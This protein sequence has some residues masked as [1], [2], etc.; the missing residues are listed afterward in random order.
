ML[1]M[2]TSTNRKRRNEKNN[3]ALGMLGNGGNFLYN[4]LEFTLPLRTDVEEAFRPIHG[5]KSSR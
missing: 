4:V 3:S 2:A 5:L 1:Q